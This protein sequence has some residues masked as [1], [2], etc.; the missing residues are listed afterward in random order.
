[1]KVIA[2]AARKGGVG[3]TFSATTL[4]V[5]LAR[6]IDNLPPLRVLYVDGDSQQNST[7]YFLKYLA[8]ETKYQTAEQWPLP[9]NPLCEHGG[10]Y[11]ISDIFA[12]QDFIE[13]PTI[14]ENLNVVPSDGGI[15]T[16]N[17]MFKADEIAEEP[18]T[19]VIH[20]FRG[21]VRLVEQDYDVMIIDTPPSR[22][23]AA[24]AAIAIADQVIVPVNLDIWNV[25]QGVPAVLGDIQNIARQY[26]NEDHDFV[27]LFLNKVSKRFNKKESTCYDL[28][29]GIPGAA[30][31]IQEEA[32]TKRTAFELESLPDDPE[33]FEYM[34]Q[35]DTFKMVKDFV[36]KIYHKLDI[37]E[38]V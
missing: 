37:Q 11:S 35:P 7:Y 22:T 32:F 16:F 8:P 15:D 24:H 38:V 36:A 14:I 28:L 18:L 31:L 19:A 30:P 29:K 10:T 3:K 5:H 25:E 13:Y 1:M 21:L 6:G 2:V 17:G 20:Q 26:R 12:G 9:S 23:Y 33:N 27:G 4:A 34:R